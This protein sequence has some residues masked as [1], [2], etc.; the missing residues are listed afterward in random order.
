VRLTP[1]LHV[2]RQWTVKQLVIGHIYSTA[3]AWEHFHTEAPMKRLFATLN[4]LTLVLLGIGAINVNRQIDL[5]GTIYSLN[6]LIRESITGQEALNGDDIGAGSPDVVAQASAAVVPIIIYDDVP[7]YD[8]GGGGY[9]FLRN[10]TTEMQVGSGT[11]FFI[12]DDG[13]LIT[14]KHVVSSDASRY[15]VDMDGIEVPAEV[16]YRDPNHDLAVIKIAGDSYPVI[17]MGD[18]AKIKLGEGISGIGN[19]FGEYTDSVSSGSVSAL[20]RSVLVSDREGKIERMRG[21][22]QTSAQLYPGDSGGPLLNSSGQA[23][24]VNVA[25]SIGEEVSF[26]IPINIAKQVAEKA[27]A[28]K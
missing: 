17:S 21:L 20:N 25:S 27:W 8:D 26:A 7:V 14:N 22:I 1:G 3:L 15:A 6:A 13:Y 2:N 12:S 18:S 19:A 28:R 23:I 10:F 5:E 16:V 4:L 9:R 11:G 24:G